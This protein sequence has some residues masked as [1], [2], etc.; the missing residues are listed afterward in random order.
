MGTK[1]SLMENPDFYD[2]LVKKQI[3]IHIV[4][5]KD[6]F[7]VALNYAKNG[8]LVIYGF[9]ADQLFGSVIGQT[10]EGDTTKEHFSC[11]LKADKAIQQYEEA[12]QHYNLPI[13]T[14]AEFL[15]FNN[16]ALKWDYVCNW[17]VASEHATHDNIVSFFN[18]FDFECWSLSNFDVLHKYDQKDVKNY[19][20]EMKNFIYEVVAL[21]SVFAL[22]KVPSIAYAEM[23][24]S[25]SAPMTA[26]SAI[27]DAGGIHTVHIPKGNSHRVG[28]YAASLLRKF[29]K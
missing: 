1:T 10:C 2:F 4:S 6:I 11:F 13:K 27:D 3:K 14:I 21:D 17:T 9:P 25:P 12:F 24:E 20:I 5:I 19:K 28:L 23:S 29:L 16:F 22:K 8:D 15:W 26:I 18:T 7:R